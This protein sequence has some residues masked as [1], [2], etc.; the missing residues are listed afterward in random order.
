M[1]LFVYNEINFYFEAHDGASEQRKVHEGHNDTEACQFSI[2]ST[3]LIYVTL[4]GTD[5]ATFGL[6]NQR[7]TTAP[8]EARMV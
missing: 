6:P 8:H 4:V 2:F 5:A 3:G 1:V 7:A